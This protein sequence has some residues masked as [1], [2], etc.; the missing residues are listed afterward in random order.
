[1]EDYKS[2]LEKLQTQ[3]NTLKAKF[4][5]AQIFTHDFLEM[6][7]EYD[8]QLV[9]IGKKTEKI[10][11]TINWPFGHKGSVFTNEAYEMVKTREND[12]SVTERKGYPAIWRVV[13]KAGIS[14]GC[15]NSHQHQ[16]RDANLIE[17][18]FE[19]KD[20]VWYWIE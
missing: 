8:I 15:G 14:G 7:K 5:S 6:C 3:I 1:M 9:S 16:V 4:E 12:D 19:L 18:V 13:S 20:G 2:Q 11:A 17:G 10:P